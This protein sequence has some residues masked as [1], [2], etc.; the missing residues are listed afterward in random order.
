MSRSIRSIRVIRVRLSTHVRLSI[1]VIRV[2]RVRFNSVGNRTLCGN[3][4]LFMQSLIGL[5]PY[6]VWHFT[7]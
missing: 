1:R 4:C 3:Q 7:P 5:Y 6:K 2:I